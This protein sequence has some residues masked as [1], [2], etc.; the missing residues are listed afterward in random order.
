ML[1]LVSLLL[2]L[3]VPQGKKLPQIAVDET[4]T[5]VTDETS[6]ALVQT[7]S[8]AQALQQSLQQVHALALTT[9]C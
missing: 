5:D 8:T 2:M 7:T 6:S 1:M 4:V 3:T 9:L